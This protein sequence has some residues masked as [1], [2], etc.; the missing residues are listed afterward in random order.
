MLLKT[1]NSPTGDMWVS[2]FFSSS[3]SGSEG[4]NCAYLQLEAIATAERGPSGRVCIS[5]PWAS[6]CL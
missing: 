5:A 6:W 2:I 3:P 1:V 4:V